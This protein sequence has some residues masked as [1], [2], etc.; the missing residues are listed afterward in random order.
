MA[1]MSPNQ[2]LLSARDL[3][4]SIE[5]GR[6]SLAPADLAQISEGD[7]VPLDQPAD[8]PVDLY[9]DDR[10]MARGQLVTVDDHY[11]VQITEIF[12]DQFPAVD[13]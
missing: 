11:C 9:I 12:P 2:T 8:A 1:G 13:D 5:L 10:L 3:A 4:V 6:V 7:I